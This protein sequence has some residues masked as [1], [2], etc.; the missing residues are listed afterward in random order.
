MVSS[1]NPTPAPGAAATAAPKVMLLSVWADA[2]GGAGAGAAW[3]A[4]VVLP[5]ARAI[6][7]SSPFALAQYLNQLARE[8]VAAERGTQPPQAPG[9]LR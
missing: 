4:R 2:G 9:G 6:E 3:H 7:F 8:G 1:P 5:D